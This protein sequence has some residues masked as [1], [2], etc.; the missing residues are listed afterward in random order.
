MP[1]DKYDY[2]NHI[3]HSLQGH[4]GSN[5][6]DAVKE[7]LGAYYDWKGKTFTVPASEGGDKKN[8][9]WVEED[10]IF[11]QVY[12]PILQRSS[13]TLKGMM[14][15]KFDKDL[16]GLLGHLDN[17]LWGGSINGFVFLVNTIDRGLP[18]DSENYYQT[19][20]RRIIDG[21]PYEFE[22]VVDNLDYVQKRLEEIDDLELLKKISAKITS[23]IDID[24]SSVDTLTMI[25]L[26][27]G[28]SK[29]L[30]DQ[31]LSVRVVTRNATLTE[32]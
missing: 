11:Y 15:S 1:F 8:D 12:S 29:S 20:K 3:R 7:V 25:K 32:R 2:I 28:I 9:G 6:Q 14:R 31:Y 21:R 16:N 23:R 22:C 10:A 18:E 30:A 13:E 19:S 4:T 17:N 5:F 27:R 26:I 24:P